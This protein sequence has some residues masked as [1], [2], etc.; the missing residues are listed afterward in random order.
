MKGD[1][2]GTNAAMTNRQSLM[3]ALNHVILEQKDD[4]AVAIKEVADAIDSSGNAE[5]SVP[6]NEFLEELQQPQ[7]R[8]TRLKVFWTAALN[9]LPSSAARDDAAA[10]VERLF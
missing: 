5:A 1:D 9:S 6:F 2:V 4:I 3:N 10:K 8:L 7:P